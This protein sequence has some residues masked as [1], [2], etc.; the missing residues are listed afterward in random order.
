MVCKAFVIDSPGGFTSV[1]SLYIYKQ[2]S[3][4]QSFCD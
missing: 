3:G 4:M 1:L 2:C